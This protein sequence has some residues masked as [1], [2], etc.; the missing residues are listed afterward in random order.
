M[1]ASFLLLVSFF[2]SLFASFVYQPRTVC[3]NH[4]DIRSL[5]QDI[6]D[7]NL[8]PSLEE[9]RKVPCPTNL[10]AVCRCASL[11]IVVHCSVSLS[12]FQCDGNAIWCCEKSTT[13][14]QEGSAA[15]DPM[16]SAEE[17]VWV[18][19]LVHMPISWCLVHPVTNAICCCEKS[20]TP[21]QEQ[22][23]AKHTMHT[24]EAVVW[25][26]EPAH[27]PILCYCALQ[28]GRCA[29]RTASC[30]LWARHAG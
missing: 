23:A 14:R 19:E 18:P 24:D 6:L 15:K 10:C 3:T 12:S 16:D 28:T 7:E 26:P 17:Q 13:P 9:L 29:G 4:T 27:M 30:L 25:V 21:R 2:L 1:S 8:P 11:C 5:V 20:T 22:S